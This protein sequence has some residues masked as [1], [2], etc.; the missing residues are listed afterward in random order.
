M[1][2]NSFTLLRKTTSLA[3]VT[4]CVTSGTHCQL[5]LYQIIPRHK[6]IQKQVREIPEEHGGGDI[7]ISLINFVPVKPLVGF[8][9]ASL[10]T[11]PSKPIKQVIIKEVCIS[12]SL[13]YIN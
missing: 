7:Q 2:I 9:Y 5:Q 8:A 3:S 13:I 1:N 11:E 12:L 4:E 10:P 6:Y